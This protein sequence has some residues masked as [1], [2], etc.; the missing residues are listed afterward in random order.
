MADCIT[1]SHYKYEKRIENAVVS[2]PLF[3][4]VTATVE[5]LKANTRLHFP[6]KILGSH[7][8]IPSRIL[9]HALRHSGMLVIH[10]N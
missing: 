8:C 10:E 2:F 1:V 5:S 6:A 7:I 4:N 3:A 9:T